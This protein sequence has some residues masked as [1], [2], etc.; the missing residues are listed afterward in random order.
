[1]F[2]NLFE[3]RQ[4][5]LLPKEILDL[6]MLSLKDADKTDHPGIAMALCTQAESWLDKLKSPTAKKS[7]APRT[8]V[9]QPLTVGVL[10][11]YRDHARIVT[12]HKHPEKALA[13]YKKIEKWG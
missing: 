1:M 9:D 2:E 5:P 6:A 3:S 10:R 8:T 4:S 13:S 11:A 12:C 7:G